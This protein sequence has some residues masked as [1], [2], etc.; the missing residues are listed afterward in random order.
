MQAAAPR[1][2]Q[3]SNSSGNDEQEKHV[4]LAIN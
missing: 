2:G 1:W 4:F 3:I